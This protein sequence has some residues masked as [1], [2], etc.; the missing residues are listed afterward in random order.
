MER[1]GLGEGRRGVIKEAVKGGWQSEEV[2]H[3]EVAGGDVG[4]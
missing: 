2:G 4:A 1:S 3:E